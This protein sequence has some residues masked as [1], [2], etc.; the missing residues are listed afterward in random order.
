MRAAN[1]TGRRE[2]LTSRPLLLA[3]VGRASQSGGQTML[4]LTPVHAQ[5]GLIKTMIA[6]V[7]A[8]IGHVR[9]IARQLPGIDRWRALLNYICERIL[10]QTALPI[11]PSRLAG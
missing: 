7:G 6:N 4:Y 5:T 2:A 3:A 10:A 1:P 11:P 8:A 9:S